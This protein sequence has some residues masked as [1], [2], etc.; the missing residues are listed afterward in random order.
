MAYKARLIPGIVIQ[1]MPLLMMF[2]FLSA[3]PIIIF[4]TVLPFSSACSTYS[5]LKDEDFSMSFSTEP[6]KEE[7]TFLTMREL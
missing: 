3:T 5:C 4:S 7:G 2:I 6:V 1:I